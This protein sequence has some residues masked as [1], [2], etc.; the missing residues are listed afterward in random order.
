MFLISITDKEA[1]KV[2]FWIQSILVAGLREKIID[3]FLQNHVKTF[4][5]SL[6]NAKS[7]SE[8]LYYS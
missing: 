5:L 4:L 1:K 8:I 2:M 3:E 6:E 7:L